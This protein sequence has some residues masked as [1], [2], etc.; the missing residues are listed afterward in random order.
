[1]PLHELVYVSLADHDLSAQE[2]CELL[3]DSRTRNRECG[4]T[5]LLIYR[6]REFMQLIEGERADVMALYERIEGDPR[7]GQLYRMWDGPISAR[8]CGLWSMAFA[9]PHEAALHALP[10]GRQIL[11][12]GLF[13]A[14]QSSAGKRILM[15]L[16]DDVL[17]QQDA[18]AAGHQANPGQ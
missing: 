6:E 7:H 12:E 9:Q 18:A 5:G 17:R 10:D 13:A 3:E 1:M 11:D 15:L 14:G 2:L 16:R 4:I 8:S